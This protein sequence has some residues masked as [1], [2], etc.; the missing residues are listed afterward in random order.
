MNKK[1]MHDQSIAS[2]LVSEE[3]WGLP[4]KAVTTLR[5]AY[6]TSGWAGYWRKRLEL[7]EEEAKQRPV[8]PV[9]L[10]QLY[11][12][13]GDKDKAFEW[14]QRAYDLHDMS[15]IFIRVDPL[16]QDVRLD[17]RFIDLL[18]RMRLPS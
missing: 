13:V 12:R 3:R 16:W 6:A 1:G 17:P 15:L 9:Y 2:Y 14:L 7:A 18:Q 11:A 4:V 8:A 5:Q 10:A